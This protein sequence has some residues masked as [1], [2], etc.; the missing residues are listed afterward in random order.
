ML[1]VDVL[2]PVVSASEMAAVSEAATVYA[3]AV[4]EIAGAVAAL[5]VVVGT[6]ETICGAGSVD[7][8]VAATDWLSAPLSAGGTPTETTLNVNDV[9]L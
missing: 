5:E 9:G 2:V 1:S 6:T 3:I 7:C 4:V 8:C